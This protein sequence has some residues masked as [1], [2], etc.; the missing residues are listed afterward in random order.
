MIQLHRK[1]ILIIIASI[2]FTAG[3][4]GGVWYWHASTNTPATAGSSDS[5]VETTD[6]SHSK[7]S[8]TKKSTSPTP[9][10][11]AQPSAAPAQPTPTLSSVTAALNQRLAGYGVIV[12]LAPAN[13]AGTYSTWASLTEADAPVL[14]E[15][16]VYL[17]DEF[18]KYPK[19]LVTNSGL[20]SIGIVKDLT[21]DGTRRSAVPVPTLSSMV[22][23]S[24]SLVARGGADAREVVSHEY[25]HYLDYK[26][27]GSWRYP[28]DQWSACNPSGFHYGSGGEGAYTESGFYNSFHP[29]AGFITNYARYGIEEDRAEMFGWLIYKPSAV[30]NLGDSGINCKINRLTQLARQLSP[31]ISF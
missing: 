16:G 10:S 31:A 12:T 27:T 26:M 4:I 3:L 13:N 19:D 7:S 20:R 22:Y 21:V 5:S 14:Q 8:T 25:W 2:I 15:F 29:T 1:Q 6:L 9:K 30:K 17:G 24:N 28:D 18:S 11:S 23:D